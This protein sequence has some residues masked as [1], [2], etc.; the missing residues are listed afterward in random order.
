LFSLVVIITGEVCELI[1]ITPS[2]DELFFG[3]AGGI[4]SK[5]L[6]DNF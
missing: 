3:I 6:P 4:N 5:I 1:E 2:G